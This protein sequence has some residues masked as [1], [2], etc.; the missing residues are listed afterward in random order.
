MI[1]VV[2]SF[3]SKRNP[4]TPSK[5]RCILFE[6]FSTGNSLNKGYRASHRRQR[7]TKNTASQV[8]DYPEVGLSV[9]VILSLSPESQ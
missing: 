6:R 2:V 7:H 1:V 9:G 4:K 3:H 8:S 5:D